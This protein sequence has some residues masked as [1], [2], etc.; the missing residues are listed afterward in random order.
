MTTP[1]EH[2]AH[3]RRVERLIATLMAFEATT[4]A[5]MS[6]LHL[7]DVLTGGSRPF[8]QTDAGVAEAVI[9]LA[10]VYGAASLVR[11]P[12][13]ARRVATATTGFAI[14]GFVV[15]LSFTIRGGDAIDIAYHATVLPLLLL[16]LAALLRSHRGGVSGAPRHRPGDQRG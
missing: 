11:N 12:P 5:I 15:G 8:Q 14:A 2:G 10:L 9:G 13:R 3:D 16:T 6:F 4:L 7:D 1:R